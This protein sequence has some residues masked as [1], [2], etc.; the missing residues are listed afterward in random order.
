MLRRKGLTVGK[1][2]A[3]EVIA[4]S[5]RKPEMSFFVRLKEQSTEPR[6]QRVEE[7]PLKKTVTFNA[8]NGIGGSNPVSDVLKFQNWSREWKRFVV[9]SSLGF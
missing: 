8:L 5:L 6:R 9:G 2:F 7:N 3:P 1:G 4:E